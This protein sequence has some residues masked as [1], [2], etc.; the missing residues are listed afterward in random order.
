MP[1]MTKNQVTHLSATNSDTSASVSHSTGIEFKG[2]KIPT[3]HITSRECLVE[4]FTSLAAL[5]YPR[6]KRL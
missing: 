4:I 1:R 6:G 5:C 3:P 2:V